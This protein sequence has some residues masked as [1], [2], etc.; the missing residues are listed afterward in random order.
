MKALVILAIR[1]VKQPLW[2]EPDGKLHQN[3]QRHSTQFKYQM[4][5][6]LY[7][8]DFG[9]PAFYRYFGVLT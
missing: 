7:I 2:E 3:L 1:S 5:L 6:Y 9:F 4:S 8:F